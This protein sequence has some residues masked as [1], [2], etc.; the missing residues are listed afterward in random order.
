MTVLA[1]IESFHSLRV[2]P[3]LSVLASSLLTKT[4]PWMKSSC[5]TMAFEAAGSNSNNFLCLELLPCLL[6]LLGQ[7]LGILQNLSEYHLF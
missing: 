1:L 4:Q 3:F 6:S 5:L 7:L 2:S